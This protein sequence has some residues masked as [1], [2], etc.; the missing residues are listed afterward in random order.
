MPSKAECLSSRPAA[1]APR[2]WPLPHS[3]APQDAVRPLQEKLLRGSTEANCCCELLAEPARGSVG[4][5]AGDAQWSLYVEGDEL[6]DAMVSTI[7]AAQ[8]SVRMESY[9]FADDAVG[10]RVAVALAESARR[11][12]E[13]RLRVDYAGSR[14]ELSDALVRE[15]KNAGVRFEWSHRWQWSRPWA[16]HRRNHRKLL[17]I[18]DAVAFVGGFNVHAASSLR[19]VGTS[20]WRDTHVRFTGPAVAHAIQIFDGAGHTL[21][22]LRHRLQSLLLIPE[23]TRRCRRRLRCEIDR[24]FR[25]ARQRIWVT[26][27][28]FVPDSRLRRRLIAAARRSVDVRVLTPAKSDV[29]LAQWAARA[30]YSGLLRHGVRVY[31]Y[32]PRVLHAKTVL[33]DDA[34]ASVGTANLDYRSLFINAEVNLVTNDATFCEELAREFLTDLEAAHEIKLE[35]WQ[36]RA[37]WQVMREKFAWPLRRWL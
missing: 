9:I 22:S 28:Y 2:P 29:P 34:W 15:L 25:S 12:R 30:L 21:Q 32:E 11:G 6:Y 3:S 24:A 18:D 8:F 37:W 5:T 10:R 27:P 14:L 17:I 16:F 4:N 35:H 13:V 23:S 19:T 36:R 7:G 26:T 20:R 1:R 31:E 33:V